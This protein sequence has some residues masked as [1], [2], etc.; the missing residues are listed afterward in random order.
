MDFAG[1]FPSTATIVN[2]GSGDTHI[3][4]NVINLDIEPFRNVDIVAVSEELPLADSSCQGVILIAVL[5]HVPN[6]DRTL[7]E[8]HR[9]LA[10]GGRVL[11]DVPFIQG[12][13]AAPA[14]HRRYTEQGLRA[15]LQRYGFE[16]EASGIAVGPAS[17][18]AWVSAEFLALLLSF[19]S[20][21]A[22]KVAKLLTSWMSWPIKFADHHLARHPMA[23]TIASAVWATAKAPEDAARGSA[24]P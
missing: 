1:S 12:Y 24:G 8:I 7:T 2:I 11:V 10:P 19:Q 14:D 15:E 4:P 22:Y 18:M 5:E 16:P 3:G 21:K 17:A 13:H 23:Y 20:V 9:V 6:A